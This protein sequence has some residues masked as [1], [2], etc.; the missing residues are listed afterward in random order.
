LKT[1]F[2]LVDF[3]NVQPKDVDLLR[4]GSFKIKVFVGPKQTKVPL[5]MA[6]A[7]QA[8]GPDA[9][10]VQ[11]SGGGSN[12]LDFHIAYYIGRLAAENPDASFQVISKDTGFDPLIRHL[13]TTGIVCERSVSIAD[14][15]KVKIPNS[16]SSA[17]RIDAVI[18]NLAKRKAAKP[19]SLKTLRSSINA[20]FVN[21]LSDEELDGLIEQLTRRGTIKITDEGVHYDS[22]REV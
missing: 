10:Y 19:R 18:D 14:I 17:D 5:D 16:S 9:E 21:Q 12:A 6:R 20:L 4:T 8:F 7:L 15:G 3:E 2:I 11:I 22:P 1:T 13:R